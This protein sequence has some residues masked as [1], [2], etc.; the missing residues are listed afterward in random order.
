MT[1]GCDWNDRLPDF[2]LGAL[3]TSAAARVEAHLQKCSECAAALADLRARS[4]RLDSALSSWVAGSAPSPG[5]RAHVLEAAENSPAPSLA[6]PAWAGAFAAVAI[7]LLAGVLMPRVSN[8]GA[9]LEPSAAPS[10]S[11]W[12][13]PTESLMRH[14]AQEFFRAAPRLGEF[15]FPLEPAPK[16]AGS[17]NGGNNES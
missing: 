13:S 5:F 12:R 9:G 4:E 11:T 10:L 6:L 14:P 16:G 7:V 17:E 1:P 8:P 3:P 15:Y 2:V